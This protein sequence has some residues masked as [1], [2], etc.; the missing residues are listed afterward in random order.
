V[1]IGLVGI[2][3]GF[4]W[5]LLQ[6]VAWTVMLLDRSAEM[7][8][9]QAMETTFDGHHPCALCKVVR[10]GRDTQQQQQTVVLSLAKTDMVAGDEA[11]ELTA[12][13]TVCVGHFITRDEHAAFKAF[14]PP[15][16]PPRRA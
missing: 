8:W 11:W 12:P 9:V 7:G 4:Q 2:S 3:L 6:S 15:W 13:P 1:V 5:T 10:K 14:P 16:Q